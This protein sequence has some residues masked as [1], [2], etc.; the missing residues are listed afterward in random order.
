[1][2]RKF[3]DL[4]PEDKVFHTVEWNGSLF[5]GKKVSQEVTVTK[6]TE[7]TIECYVLV[8]VYRRF[9]YSRQTGKSFI[10]PEEIYLTMSDVTDH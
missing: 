5:K 3:S 9:E 10:S 1:M 2:V 8:D 4:K 6:V 7:E